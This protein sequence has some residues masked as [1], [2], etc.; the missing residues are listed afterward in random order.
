MPAIIQKHNATRGIK[1]VD[2]PEIQALLFDVDGV[3]ADT[4]KLHKRAWARIASEENWQFDDEC[5]EDLRG[6]SREDSLRRI[7]NGR[8][9]DA[10]LFHQ[11]MERK[12]QYY[13]ESLRTL[14]AS[15]A[16]AG[17][18]ELIS[19]ASNL[20]LAIAAVSASR[21]ART[22]IRGIGLHEDLNAIVDGNTASHCENR[23]V[24]AA[25]LLGIR[26]QQCLVFEDS[27]AGLE[28]ARSA[29]MF[30]IGLGAHTRG[31]ADVVLPSLE[32]CSFKELMRRLDA[33]IK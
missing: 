13:V 6:L 25:E 27:S 15:D 24:F 2:R 14:R 11:L 17:V 10:S 22:V 4:A 8:E 9:I 12:N 7:L 18:R 20:N 3:L 32:N 21:N 1:A 19:D 30:T 23:Y 28:L 26:R 16:L 5:A 33:Q 29:G 31:A